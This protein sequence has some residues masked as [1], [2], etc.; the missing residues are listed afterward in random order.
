[1]SARCLTISIARWEI[2]VLLHCAGS[3]MLARMQ[4]NRLHIGR[5]WLCLYYLLIGGSCNLFAQGRTLAYSTLAH[6][7]LKLETVVLSSEEKSTFN[8]EKKTNYLNQLLSACE[9]R[10]GIQ[11]QANQYS[12]EK[13]KFVL[14]QIDSVLAEQGYFTCIKVEYLS[15]TLTRS[16]KSNLEC[17]LQTGNN[18]RKQCLQK[19]DSIYKVDCD[20]GSF[21]YLSIAQVLQL[22]LKLIEVPKHNFVRWEFENGRY[23]NWDVNAIASFSDEAYRL[24]RTPASYIAFD[25]VQE[26]QFGYLKSK[27][28]SETLGYYCFVL[29]RNYKRTRNYEQASRYYKLAIELQP[30]HP[31]PKMCMAYLLTFHQEVKNKADLFYANQLAQEAVGCCPNEPVYIETLACTY[32][33]LGN[34][35]L[36]LQTLSQSSKQKPELIQ[37]FRNKKSGI[38]VY[39]AVD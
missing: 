28:D 10:I 19:F 8:I 13:A 2:V 31:L 22:P 39:A 27:S 24:G 12:E 25:L 4:K 1:M 3:L 17:A 16:P 34:Y 20:I 9:K 18:Y 30:Q 32:A 37:A 21:L 35:E 15:Q 14:L 29:G 23:L 5:Y 7:L 36:A 33:R 26:N 6:D 38:E 11:Q